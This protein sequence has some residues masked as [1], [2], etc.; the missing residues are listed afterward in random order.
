MKLETRREEIL[1]WLAEAGFVTLDDMA[2]RFGVSK[3]TIH[4]DLD[5][6]EVAG[7]LRK[8][9][10][11]ASIEASAQFEADYRFRALRHIAQKRQIAQAAAAMVETGMRVM[12][13]DGSTAAL[14]A[15]A[16][17]PRDRITIITNNHAAIEI[18]Q[19]AANITLITLGGR[20]SRKFH[21]AT[22][23]VTEAAIAAMRADLAFISSPAVDGAACYHMDEA[24]RGTKAAMIAAAE[25]PVLMAEGAKFG[26]NALY[27]LADLRDFASVLTHD[28]PD[29]PRAALKDLGVTITD[30][31]EA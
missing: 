29:G 2:L 20:Y 8:M 26:R 5:D 19:D 3:M 25:R 18:L 14:L 28:L 9:R 1:V 7:L 11:G 10:G 21:C 12:L 4:R 22:G 17:G 13:S 15:E 27:H 23:H 30:T 31:K 24:V 6:L 16:L